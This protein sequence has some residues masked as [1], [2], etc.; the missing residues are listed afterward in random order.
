MKTIAT[1]VNN[2]VFDQLAN[3][4]NERGI[5][6]SKKLRELIVIEQKEIDDDLIELMKQQIDDTS[7]TGKECG[8][9]VCENDEIEIVEKGTS[10]S[11]TLKK[12]PGLTLL[13][14]THPCGTP[15]PSEQ[16]FASVQNIHTLK[17]TCIGT[18]DAIRCFHP[19]TGKKTDEIHLS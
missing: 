18:T 3:E 4:C 13:F 17:K 12:C 9:T 8:F 2:H 14:H 6:M 16:D 11:V 10:N 15:F 5:T 7:Y 19:H 1:K